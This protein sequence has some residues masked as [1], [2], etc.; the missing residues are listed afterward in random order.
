MNYKLQEKIEIN[1][2][3]PI[4]NKYRRMRALDYS[5][6]PTGKCGQS[7]RIRKLSFCNHNSKD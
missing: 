3:I 6:V 7:I 5:R 4:I 1:E 2:S